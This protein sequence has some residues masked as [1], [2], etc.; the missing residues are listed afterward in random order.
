MPIQ[1]TRKFIMIVKLK[2]TKLVGL[3]WLVKQ[4]HVWLYVT[5]DDNSFQ[6]SHAGMNGPTSYTENHEGRISNSL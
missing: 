5:P 6:R 4:F 2:Y 1:Y 3:T